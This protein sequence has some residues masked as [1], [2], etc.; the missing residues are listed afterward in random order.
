MIQDSDS[1]LSYSREIKKASLRLAFFEMGFLS[2]SPLAT[3][4]GR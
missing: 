3:K 2:D 1:V 4:K